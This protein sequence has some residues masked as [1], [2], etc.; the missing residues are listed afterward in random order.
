M[1]NFGDLAGMMKQFQ[2]IKE[3]IEKTK[4]QLKNEKIVVEVGG[5]TVKV[6]V[7]GL[8]EILDIDIDQS[9]LSDKEVLKDLLISGINEAME[10]SKEL[11]TERIS[12][13]SGLPLSFGKLGG[14][15]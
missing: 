13:A 3:N 9:L 11:M 8:G 10:R 1:F 7:N 15:F 2:T 4:Q 14:L 6:V 5:G 12:Q